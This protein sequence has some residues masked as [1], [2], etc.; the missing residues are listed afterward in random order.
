MTGTS[1]LGGHFILC[2]LLSA[3]KRT[4]GNGW[5]AVFIFVAVYFPTHARTL[6]HTALFKIK[7]T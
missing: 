3:E 6:I 1:T 7:W 5:M 4:G 2:F